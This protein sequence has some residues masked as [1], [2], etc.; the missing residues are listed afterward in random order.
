[1]KNKKWWGLLACALSASAMAQDALFSA[2]SKAQGAPFDHVVTET[3]R[4]PNK[5]ELRVTAFH[6]RTAAGSRWFMCAYTA[7]AMERGFAYWT[8]VYPAEGDDRIVL[9][10]S[11]QETDSPRELLGA[12]FDAKRTLDNTMTAVAVMNRMCG[13]R[14]GEDGKVRAPKA[15]EN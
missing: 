14:L 4:W 11:Q 13:I 7:L 8:V 1:M 6:E 3:Q 2:S 15:G 9:G 5:S 12:D 10:L